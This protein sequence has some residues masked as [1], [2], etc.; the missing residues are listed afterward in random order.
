MGLFQLKRSIK[1][2]STGVIMNA[3]V[4]TELADFL[5]TLIANG[6]TQSF[7]NTIRKVDVLCY[8]R[9]T[10]QA[11]LNLGGLMISQTDGL[12]Y[13]FNGKDELIRFDRIQF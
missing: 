11:F 4:S 5:K 1:N 6:F 7:T 2:V 10:K 12:I 3:A 13:I 9:E 8:Y